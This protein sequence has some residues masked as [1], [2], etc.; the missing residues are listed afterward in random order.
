MLKGA[1]PQLVA[2]YGQSV[3]VGVRKTVVRCRE[4]FKRV[5]LG[6]EFVE[7][8]IL[9]TNPEI[10][11]FILYNLPYG[12]AL[13]TVLARLRVVGR[14]RGV[15]LRVITQSAKIGAAPNTA[16]FILGECIH[17]IIRKRIR[18]MK[19]IPQMGI[20]LILDMI[21]IYTRLRC[22]PIFVRTRF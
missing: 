9:G 20:L 3:D 14:K 17:G 8:G 21:N 10:S 7:T 15:W 5:R 12:I 22:H 2:V 19:V 1:Y 18:I 13:Y 4:I 16:F 6:I 11:V